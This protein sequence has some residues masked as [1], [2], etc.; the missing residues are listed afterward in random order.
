MLK[1]FWRLKWVSLAS[2]IVLI[3][4][5]VATPSVQ[6]QTETL[7]HSFRNWPDGANP[8]AGLIRDAAGNLYGTTFKGGF[9]GN[10]I[11][12]DGCGTVFKV[13][14]AGKETVLYRFTGSDGALPTASLVRDK[15]GNLYGTT[16]DGGVPGV[17]TV[18]K[19]DATGH[20]TVLHSFTGSPDGA[21]P[22]AGLILDAGGNLYGTTDVGGAKAAGTV[23]EVDT[24]G[25][26]T[27]LYSFTGG[28]DVGEPWGGVI[29]DKAGNL[30]GTTFGGGT[31]GSGTVFKIAP[32]GT[33]TVL[34]SFA[35]G[36]DGQFPAAGVIMDGAGNLYGTTKYGG[37]PSACNG[38]GCGTVFKLA[39]N[40]TETVLYSF[41]GGADGNAPLAGVIRD[42]GGNLYGTTNVGGSLGFG[43]VFKLDVSG[44][45]TVLH[46]FAGNHGN[47]RD[48]A[49]PEGSLIRDRAGHLYGTTS[50]GGKYQNVRTNVGTVFKLSP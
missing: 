20:E 24:S 8:Q 9:K 26:E 36:T 19:L 46:S 44:R 30:Y 41:S 31:S 42:A 48:G 32:N 1:Q 35:G 15:A 6:A 45:E 16:L 14:K 29:R 50:I 23:F 22:L 11:C 37:D 7:L 28:A 34:Y 25:K 39:R 47:P 13:S 3:P 10:S 43:T 2:A 27:V 38:F 5:I 12:G 21:N 18:F 49:L 33:E 4:V 40:G 17:G